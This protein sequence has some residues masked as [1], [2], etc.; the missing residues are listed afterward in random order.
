MVLYQMNACF[1]QIET[2]PH[3]LFCFLRGDSGHVYFHHTLK[4]RHANRCVITNTCTQLTSRRNLSS[5]IKHI[6]YLH[7]SR[8]LAQ[9]GSRTQICRAEVRSNRD[10]HSPYSRTI[11]Y[12]L[13]SSTPF[14]SLIYIRYELTGRNQSGLC[15]S[16]LSQDVQHGLYL[17]LPAHQAEVPGQGADLVPSA[18]PAVASE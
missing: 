15:L 8:H 2:S 3:F 5:L 12:Y 18:D 11:L 7:S 16:F 4:R 6:N 9:N 13:T 17:R 1:S 14:T 10:A